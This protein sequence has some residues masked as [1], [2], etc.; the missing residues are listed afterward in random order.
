MTATSHDGL[1]RSSPLVLGGFLGSLGLLV[2][3]IAAAALI[4]TSPSQ[5]LPLVLGALGA[6]VLT[7]AVCGV[8]SLRRHRWTIE[9]D[10]VLIEERPLVP[11]FGLR[12]VRRL[13]FAAIA[14]LNQVPNGA[15]ELL[16]LTSRDGERFV[17]APRRGDGPRRKPDQQGLAA[18]AAQLQAAMAAAGAVA[19][20]VTDGLGFWNRPLGLA[21]LGLT[22]AVTVT[23]AAVVLWGLSEGAIVRVRTHAAA[24]FLVALPIPVAWMLYRCWQRRRSVM[25][26]NGS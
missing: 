13:P 9:A 22:L 19:P 5:R 6:F 7:F 16:A 3:G 2:A 11:M 1:Y 26:A 23:V 21:L 18:F 12:R 4:A 24:A 14:A 15:D 20:P 8:V 17:L 25:R 10:G